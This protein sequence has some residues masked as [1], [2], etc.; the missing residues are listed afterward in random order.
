M[1][2][3]AMGP[4]SAVADMGV[5]AAKSEAKKFADAPILHLADRLVQFGA[6][7]FFVGVAAYYM[8]PKL[9]Q[10]ATNERNDME[11]VL[12]L[13]RTLP[14][15]T[16]LPPPP[17]LTPLQAAFAQLVT[18]VANPDNTNAALAATQLQKA[19]VDAQAFLHL[20]DAAL[21]TTASVP[22]QAE[23]LAPG[24]DNSCP[25]GYSLE[26]LVEGK[27]RFMYRCVYQGKI[28]F[29]T[30]TIWTPTQ[31]PPGSVDGNMADVIN[32]LGAAITAL[33]LPATDWTTAK[34]L[35]S[36][37]HVFLNQVAD[38]YG[39]SEPFQGASIA[40]NANA[41]V[42]WW[43]GLAIVDQ[44][45]FNDLGLGQVASAVYNGAKTLYNDA[46][47][48]AGDVA[49]G[50]QVIG[51]AIVNA[52][53]VIGDSVGF[54]W[55]WSWS[56]VLDLIGPIFL[57]MGLLLLMVGLVTKYVYTT[58]WPH[59]KMRLELETNARQA[60]LWNRVDKRLHTRSKVQAIWTLKSTEGQ[61]AS[62]NRAPFYVEE[63]TVLPAPE[64]PPPPSSIEAGRPAEAQR[65]Q[66]EKVEGGGPSQAPPP[67]PTPDTPPP[68][69]EP[70]SPEPAPQ[71]PTE[72]AEA[73][74]GEK[75][76]VP[77]KEELDKIAS[78]SEAARLASLPPEHVADPLP[79]TPISAPMEPEAPPV[80]EET[81]PPEP[82][83]RE[84][85][86]R[87]QEPSA[88]QLLNLATARGAEEE[89]ERQTQAI[90]EAQAAR[91]AAKVAMDVHAKKPLSRRNYRGAF[92]GVNRAMSPDAYG[93]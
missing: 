7:F 20:A 47:A 17:P 12:G 19:V 91:R 44:I 11:D 5:E 46:S 2:A 66:P 10:A 34:S 36:A 79:E 37:V 53:R 86:Y 50:L 31:V 55:N 60:G 57:G 76:R 62:A 77:T 1:A 64:V 83:R 32:D 70:P 39:W 58:I 72:A 4:V 33:Q 42:S 68:P 43:S 23:T 35:V 24:P 8:A 38:S 54:V 40:A 74:L 30:E 52:P 84:R 88:N 9:A 65:T 87:S 67:E 13:P 81:P 6:A 63:P 90:K 89:Y 22:N 16:P 59:L 73:S 82:T 56:Q 3:A 21:S 45:A 26:K 27:D 28:T 80:A 18:D 75:N 85:F 25:A 69:V 48:V 14:P 92:E 71:T 78:E 49:K 93:D 41:Q 15:G 29:T 61:I 51:A